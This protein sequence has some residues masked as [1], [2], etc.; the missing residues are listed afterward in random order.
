[1]LSKIISTMGSEFGLKGHHVVLVLGEYHQWAL[2]LT[3]LVLEWKMW[4]LSLG[5]CSVK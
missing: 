5:V 4:L 2:D 1:M 3:V